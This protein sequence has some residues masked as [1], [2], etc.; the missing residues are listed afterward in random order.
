VASPVEPEARSTVSERV[1]P[2]DDDDQ[3]RPGSR[4]GRFFLLERAGEGGMGV[5][6]LAYDPELHRKV[7]IKLLRRATAR[8][9]ARLIREAQALAQVSHPNLVHVYEVGTWR[10]R[11]FVAMQFVEGR[12]L[13]RWLAEQKRDWTAILD[14]FLAAGEGL[15]AAHRAGIVHRD[16]KPS[17]VLVSDD[18]T[19]RVVDFGLAR[20]SGEAEGELAV[21][22]TATKAEARRKALAPVTQDGAVIGTPPYLAPEQHLGAAGDQRSDQYAFCVS[23][24][25]SLYGLRPF[26]GPS[27]DELRRQKTSSQI[28]TPPSSAVPGWLHKVILRGL[29]APPS[30]RF[31]S[32]QAL[33]DVL[34]RKRHGRPRFAAAL[35]VAARAGGVTAL[36]VGGDDDEPRSCAEVAAEID[37]VWNSQRRA[38]IVTAFRSTGLPYANDMLD[39]VQQRID[40]YVQQW[41]ELRAEA[42]EAT[43]VRG[44]QSDELMDLRMRCLDQRMA[45]LDALLGAFGDANDSVVERAVFSVAE[46]PRLQVCSDADALRARVQLPD[47]ARV[48]EA[49]ETL[50]HELGWVQMQRT[51][52]HFADARVKAEQVVKAAAQLG[53][54]PLHAK[55]LL[56]LGHVLREIDPVR[57]EPTLR[58]ALKMAAIARDDELTAEIWIVLERLVGIDLSRHDEGLSLAS[59]TEA[60]LERAGADDRRRAMHQSNIG[61]M[62][63][64]K[65][66]YAASVK[67]YEEAKA[68]VR[69]AG[70]VDDREY[71][72]IMINYGYVL[73][74]VGRAA[75]AERL[76]AEQIELARETLGRRHP[77]LADHLDAH[78][79]AL[80]VLGR[81]ADARKDWEEAL[82]ILEGRPENRPRISKLRGNLAV[83][84]HALGDY[85]AARLHAAASADLA[86][87][88]YGAQHL[89]VAA[90]VDAIGLIDLAE[91][92]PVRAEERF[93]EALAIVEGTLGDGHPIYADVAAND[94]TALVDLG[95]PRDALDVLARASA[96]LE[97]F[98]ATHPIRL[99]AEAIGAEARLAENDRADVVP[100]LERAIDGLGEH[101][102]RARA[103]VMFTL[104]RAI[105]AR[106]PSRARKLATDARATFDRLDDAQHERVTT[107]LE[108]VQ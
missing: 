96:A 101:N 4:L 84:C 31:E 65:G 40:A 73:Q 75:E 48:R 64:R 15:A 8:H 2:G 34:A 27:L 108:R 80:E 60:A 89:H 23:L 29:E 57:A 71:S 103:R 12:T 35:G 76:L 88:I 97:R 83:A 42:C 61:T 19:V 41:Q 36:L 91:G 5:V 6:M 102:S 21:A 105:H 86:R 45:D 3:P 54:A 47:D 13:T 46:L 106:D 74:L 93:A 68:L 78:A 44:T 22:P 85:A 82:T 17:N 59:G 72:T 51:S 79:A 32:M 104:A 55:A 49:I 81:P 70:A 95:R 107:W 53:H 63:Q 56:A 37:G 66:D 69:E 62:L 90:P 50:T 77:H 14:V 87:E 9:R 38:T 52:G 10:G 94:A 100:A 58:E 33:L 30:D 20:L 67:A 7:A 99:R 98:P 39:E 11:V 28:A 24:F 26:S 25:E 16:F 92:E 43:R 1:A 18:G